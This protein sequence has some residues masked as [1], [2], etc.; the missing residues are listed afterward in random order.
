MSLAA[1]PDVPHPPADNIACSAGIPMPP[2][3][4]RTTIGN[5]IHPRVAKRKQDIACAVGNHSEH[6]CPPFAEPG[7]Y[8]AGDH[9]LG[10][11]CRMPNAAS[12]MP[13]VVASQ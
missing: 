13:I 9:C 5:A 3:A 8:R 1:A 7:G 11:E 2:E 12:E 10:S 4:S 6:E